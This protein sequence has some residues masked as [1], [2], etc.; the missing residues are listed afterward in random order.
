MPDKHYQ[1]RKEW[2][3]AHYKRIALDV[4]PELHERFKSACEYFNRSMR[5]QLIH[6]VS[7]FCDEMERKRNNDER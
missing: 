7:D 3:A 1:R 4:T 5:T 2:N 6:L